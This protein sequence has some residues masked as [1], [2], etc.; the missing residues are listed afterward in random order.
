MTP[1]YAKTITNLITA[2]SL[3]VALV[4]CVFSQS[5]AALNATQHHG[6]AEPCSEHVAMADI[7]LRPDGCL[8]LCIAADLNHLLGTVF[9][10]TQVSEP[11][12]VLYGYD[13]PVPSQAVTQ[14]MQRVAHNR[15]SPGSDL[16]L[17][18]RRIRL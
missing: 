5:H 14:D 18:T 12:A 3:V 7:P 1:S 6:V 2:L 9:D 10:H 13:I 16:Y 11:I 4:V 17:T 8:T 15:G